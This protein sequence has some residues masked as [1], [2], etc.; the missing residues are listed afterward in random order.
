MG[1]RILHKQNAMTAADVETDGSGNILNRPLMRSKPC[2]GRPETYFRQSREE[3]TVDHPDGYPVK[4]QTRC[5]ACAVVGTKAA[6]K[7]VAYERVHSDRD[8][9]R[10]LAAWSV[11]AKSLAKV[12]PKPIK[13]PVNDLYAGNRHGFPMG[14]LWT[15]FKRAVGKRGPFD[16]CNDQALREYADH[17]DQREREK[18][19][20]RKRTY[21]AR[22]LANAKA[23][24]IE[25]DDDFKRAAVAERDR[26]AAA[27]CDAIGADD[28]PRYVSRLKDRGAHITADVWLGRAILHQWGRSAQ[29]ADIARWMVSDDRD[30][31][32]APNSLIARIHKDVKRVSTLENGTPDAPPFWTAF[33]P[34]GSTPAA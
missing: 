14:D 23:G 33:D 11:A 12:L 19:A 17:L 24:Q 15:T 32:L 29:P 18:D 9:Q 2:F 21:R 34:L 13:N 28:A 3:E 31:G 6:C 20:R 5:G 4:K 1:I 26:R 27:L 7:K 10:H 30:H 16:D 22:V 25:P 8:M